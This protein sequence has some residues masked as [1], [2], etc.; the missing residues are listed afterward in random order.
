[1]R[2]LAELLARRGLKVTGRDANPGP[3]GDL[4]AL[5]IIVAEG[6][7]AAHLS[8]VREVVT[9]TAMSRNHPELLL[10]AVLGIP[11]IRRAEAPGEAVSGG[12]L[13]CIAGSYGKTTTTVM[14]TSA[15]AAADLKPIGIA[16]GRV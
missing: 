3:T 13:V 16:G 8:G 10:A 2:A 4:E 7:D 15:L 6:H 14:T 12:W 9:T 11:I 1:M 5:G